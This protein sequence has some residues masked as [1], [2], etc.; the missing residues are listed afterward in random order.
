[1][2]DSR[3]CAQPASMSTLTPSTV[4]TRARVALGQRRQERGGVHAVLEGH[5]VLGDGVA[6]ATGAHLAQRLASLGEVL[7][8]DGHA[9]ERVAAVVQVGHDDAAV[10]LAPDHGAAACIAR[11]TWISPTGDRSTSW[12]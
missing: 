12:P 7:E 8:H 11:T 4:E 5:L 10:A 3:T 1:M 2:L 6:R 9:H